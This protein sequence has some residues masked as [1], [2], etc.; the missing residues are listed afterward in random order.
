MEH[1][2]I[3]YVLTWFHKD[4]EGDEFLVGECDL[5]GISLDKLLKLFDQPAE[6]KMVYCYP[7]KPK[8]LDYVQK[9]SS[10]KIDLSTYDYFV[11]GQQA[12]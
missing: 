8:Q 4:E 10:H 6:E 11:E 1:D 7:L 9:F 12:D 3:K 2:G 5:E